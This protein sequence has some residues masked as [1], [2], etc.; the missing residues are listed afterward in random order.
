[1]IY[2][3][4]LFPYNQKELPLKVEIEA[5]SHDAAVYL[6]RHTYRMERYRMFRFEGERR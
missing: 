2:R 5:E 6:L 1:M 3:F 4:T